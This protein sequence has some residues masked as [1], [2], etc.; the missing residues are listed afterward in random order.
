MKCFVRLFAI[1]SISLSAQA[2]LIGTATGIITRGCDACALFPG[3]PQPTV[4]GDHNLFGLGANA[5]LTGLNFKFTFELADSIFASV[6]HVDATGTWWDTTPEQTPGWITVNDHTYELGGTFPIFSR[7]GFRPDR[8]FFSFYDT[9]Y[10]SP[11]F[12]DGTY[13]NEINVVTL[14]DGRFDF[15]DRIAA[16]DPLL[17]FVQFTTDFDAVIK[18]FT[19]KPKA[20]VPEPTPIALLGIGLAAVI[21]F[22][23]SRPMQE[24]LDAYIS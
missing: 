2:N 20:N 24:K 18:S 22:R 5:D 6:A 16:E 17:G 15:T 12:N 19:L 9:E 21:F 23:K 10:N 1:F 13:H 4:F 7:I 3:A 8:S 14:G 11:L